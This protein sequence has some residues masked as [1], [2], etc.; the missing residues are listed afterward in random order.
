[1]PRAIAAARA[2]DPRD[3]ILRGAARRLATEP[4]AT[5]ADIA[6]ETGVS[7]ATVYRYFT[8]RD[9]LL[10]ALDL[11]PHPGTEER[12]LA[13]AAEL[14]GRDGLRTLSMDELAEQAGVSRAS[15]YRLFPG[16]TALF[17]ALVT[18][19]SPFAI[20]EETLNRLGDRPPE[21]VLPAVARNAATAMAPRIG[22]ART[23]LFEVTAGEPEAVAAVEPAI[24]QLLGTLGR[25]L[26]AQMAAGR[27]RRMHPLL[28]AQ[29]LIGPVFFHLL[30]RPV[31]LR[32]A[33]FDLELEEAVTAL[34]E[35]AVRGMLSERSPAEK[36]AS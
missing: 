28:A 20:V 16:K 21:E 19:Y 35:A 11:E 18:A 7:R 29:L 13:A 14:V 9:E 31:A 27:I 10:R 17:A 5:L 25:Y 8:S 34:A 12:I 15:V 4:R 26:A 3:R 2:A 1:M 30:T 36:G 23:L 33:Q 22:I 6:V 32:V 24:R